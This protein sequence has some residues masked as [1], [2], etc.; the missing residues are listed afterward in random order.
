MVRFLESKS[1]WDCTSVSRQL[2]LLNH[3]PKEARGGVRA[4]E[5]QKSSCLQLRGK[6]CLWPV[7]YFPFL[8]NCSLW[9]ERL[10]KH[11][12]KI[13]QN[14]QKGQKQ[15]WESGVFLEFKSLHPHLIACWDIITSRRCTEQR[16]DPSKSRVSAGPTVCSSTE[17]LIRVTMLTL[18]RVGS[19]SVNRPVT[20]IF[21][22]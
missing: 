16:P 6:F 5:A 14:E 9:N 2:G 7:V 8:T 19:V 1:M 11:S 10:E 3:G 13:P 21:N 15:Q 18:Q 17:T 20:S 4:W 12:G 22:P